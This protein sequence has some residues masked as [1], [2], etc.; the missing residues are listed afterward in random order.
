[1]PPRRLRRRL[2]LAALPLGVLLLVFG[3]LEWAG[4]RYVPPPPPVPPGFL[5]DAELGWRLAPGVSKEW[6]GTE[7]ETNRL[8]LRGDEPEPGEDV[9]RIL[10]SGDSSAMGFG[11]PGDQTFPHLLEER[12]DARTQADVQNGG[13]AGYTC[14]QSLRQFEDLRPVWEPDVLV[15]YDMHSDARLITAH[16]R[17][18]ARA[19]PSW[20]T[21]LAAGR[22]LAWWRGRL[23]FRPGEP[24]VE[25]E[26]YEDCLQTLVKRQRNLGG[27]ALLVIPVANVDL[28]PMGGRPGGDDSADLDDYR[29]RMRHVAERQQVPLVDLPA[30]FGESDLTYPEAML[31][32]VHPTAAGN[33]VI[34]RAIDEALVQEAIVPP[35]HAPETDTGE[36]AGDGAE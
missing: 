5:P 17:G 13:V 7:L 27:R 9:L 23:A 14:P 16:D 2:A 8:G 20:F 32:A 24:F 31:D 33:A 30:V 1:M 12:L 19:A 21:R 4:R 29:R 10:V 25:P 15:V 6:M 22:L 36:S 35:P 34:A 11:L 18:I 28:V 26:E 3:F